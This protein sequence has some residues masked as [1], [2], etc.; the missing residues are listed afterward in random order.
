MCPAVAAHQKNR[1]SPAQ[2]RGAQFDPWLGSSK[3]EKV[4]KFGISAAVTAIGLLAIGSV[5]SAQA[6]TILKPI[7]FGVAAGGSIPLSDFGKGYSTGYNVTGTVGVNPAGLPV[8]F[9][10][11]GA[12]NQ[13]GAKGVSSINAKIA[14]ITGNAVY[15][16]SGLEMTPYLIG[17]VGYYRASSSVAGSESSSNFGVNAGAGL[18][19]PL[20]GFSVFIEAR[21]NH[22]TDNGGSTSYVP[23][24]VG[25]LF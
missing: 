19:I 1:L 14:S 5:A 13:F 17:G 11:D 6:T 7:Q 10:I 16:M 21:Y 4:R 22:F 18:R 23:V 8:G 2:H 24:T 3:G 12:Y 20:T 15:N 25:V 9:R